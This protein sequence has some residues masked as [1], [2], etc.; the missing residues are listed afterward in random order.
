MAA[1]TNMAVYTRSDDALLACPPAARD[2]LLG[3]MRPVDR[4]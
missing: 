3:L 1:R 4:C 2:W